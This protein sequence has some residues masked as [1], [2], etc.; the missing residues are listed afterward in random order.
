MLTCFPK[1]ILPNRAKQK[2][3]KKFVPPPPTQFKGP[4]KKQ[5]SATSATDANHDLLM[6]FYA[7][8]NPK[9]ATAAFV[10]KTLLKYRGREEVLFAKLQKKY[11]KNKP[12]GKP[13]GN[14]HAKRVRRLWLRTCKYL[15]QSVLLTLS[16]FSLHSLFFLQDPE[17]TDDIVARLHQQ[18][19]DTLGTLAIRHWGV[20]NGGLTL[21]SFLLVLV[22][23]G[24]CLLVLVVCSVCHVGAP[25]LPYGQTM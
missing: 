20:V 6:S 16:S 14:P 11:M 1:G 10:A 23:G 21:R 7:Q 19:Y 5:S 25:W 12:M 18:A 24:C 17:L 13:L 8:H 9:K 4:G 2:K 15:A 3:K 22:V